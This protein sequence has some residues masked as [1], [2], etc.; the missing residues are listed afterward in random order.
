MNLGILKVE[1]REEIVKLSN[2]SRVEFCHLM[3]FIEYAIFGTATVLIN[4]INKLI[5]KYL[6]VMMCDIV[7]LYFLRIREKVSVKSRLRLMSIPKY[8]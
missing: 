3:K 7:S 5:P 6:F 1:H 4:L 8:L 2:S